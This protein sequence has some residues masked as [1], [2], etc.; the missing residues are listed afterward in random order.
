VAYALGIDVGGTKILAGVI[1]LSTGAPVVTAKKKT[2]AGAGA[3]DLIKRIVE[4]AQ[5][6]LAQAQALKK[7]PVYVEVGGVGTTGVID[8]DR[9]ILIGSPNLGPG[10]ANVPLADRL[11]KEL[12]LRISVGNDVEVATLGE[13]RFGAGKG[14]DT[15]VCIFIGTGIGGGIV[16]EGQYRYGA[17]H[18][19]GEIGHAIIAYNGRLCSC[20]GRG[21]LEAYASRAAITRVLM[22]E[23]RRG[24]PTTLRAALPDPLPDVHDMSLIRSQTIS[25][26]IQ[27]NDDLTVEAV[28]DGARYLAAGLTAII[29]FYNPPRIILG[30]GLVNAVDLYFKVAARKALEDSLVAAQDSVKIVRTKLGDN[31]GIVGA[32]LLGAT[33]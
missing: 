29:N 33:V 19:A 15:F 32:A 22:E 11:S 6:A 8:R 7:G 4:V 26:A 27:D 13:Q 20:G 5:D 28:T 24:R 23:I 3:E 21:H 18:S 1:D 12:K 25:Q 30:G 16:Q 14:H 2:K 10:V 31:A 17:S 9:G